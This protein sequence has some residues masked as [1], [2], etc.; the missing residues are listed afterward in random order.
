MSGSDDLAR[1]IA[2]RDVDVS[3]LVRRAEDGAGAEAEEVLR[4][5]LVDDLLRRAA[6]LLGRRTAVALV[7]IREG[8]EPIVRDL[9][10]S[11]LEDEV[12]L[13][14]E[15]RTHNELLLDA[16]ARGAVIP[17]RFG[18]AF[19]DADALEAWIVAHREALA[20]ELER[21][22]GKTEWS[23][24][25]LAAEAPAD[26][27]RYLDERLAT[28]TRPDV[29]VRLAEL[30]EEASGSA[31][32]L[33]EENRPAFEALVAELEAE[34]YELRISGPWPPYTFAKLP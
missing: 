1:A 27:A 6:A 34:G 20:A 26:P 28:A 7:G 2:G 3:D 29:R 4:G 30:A 15:V 31:Y 13:E 11:A 24:E 23:V 19:P 17:F 16:C 12:R 33:A 32:L 25:V 14:R 18:T 5:L 8:V 10:E 9:D 22:R 21:L